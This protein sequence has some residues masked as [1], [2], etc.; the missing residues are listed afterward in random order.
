MRFLCVFAMPRTG[1]SHLNKLFRSC[2][3]FQGKSELFH[4]HAV[5]RHR[6][7]EWDKVKAKSEGAVTDVESFRTWRRMH[8]AATLEALHDAWN[9]KKVI[10]FKVFPNHLPRDVIESQL[11]PRDDIGFAILR[12][13]PIESFISAV[14]AKMGSTFTKAD[15]TAIK[16]E[17]H[18]KDFVLWAKRMKAWYDWTR[19]VLEARGKPFAEISFE[20]HLDGLSGEESLRTVLEQLRPLGFTSVSVPQGVIVGERQD[21]ERNYKDR[22]S[23]WAAFEADLRALPERAALLDWAETVF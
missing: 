20:K 5:G 1:S 8:P 3:E 12:R 16:P 7:F 21:K 4:R 15:T 10:A 23:N 13:R 18:A 22:V 9:G 14:K 11:L 2:P 19:A 17:I 6:E